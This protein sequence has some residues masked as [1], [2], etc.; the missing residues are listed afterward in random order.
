MK[1]MKEKEKQKTVS[2]ARV[3]EKKEELSCSLKHREG[4]DSL[5]FGDRFKE[6]SGSGCYQPQYVTLKAIGVME[7][8]SK[9]HVSFH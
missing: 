6:V 3:E 4:K 5:T 1:K 7:C 9:S 2:G 8:T